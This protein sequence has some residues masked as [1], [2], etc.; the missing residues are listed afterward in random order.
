MNQQHAPWS[1]PSPPNPAGTEPAGA[2]APAAGATPVRG[3]GP[4]S[5]VP[6][7]TTALTGIPDRVPRRVL[8]YHRLAHADPRHEW[9]KPLVEGLILIAGYLLL[10]V[11]FG[12]VFFAV[13]PDRL[14]LDDLL[15]MDQLDPAVFFFMF[16]SVALLLP[17]TL[18]ARLVTGPRPLGLLLSVT[19]RI[20]WGWM[21]RCAL[22]ALGIYVVVNGVSAALSVATGGRPEPPQP[23]PGFWWL[24]LLLVV[25][26]PLQCA[27]EELVF[28]G[29]LAQAV[30]RWLRH[31]AWAVLLP[32]PLF[33]AG[34]IYDVWGLSSVGVMAVTMGV[35]TWRTGGLEAGIAL[36]AVNNCFVTFLGMLGLAD[37]NDTTGAPL[38]LVYELA[39]NALFLV[40]VFR[41]TRRSGIAVTR[42][43]LLPA[44]PRPPATAA[45]PAVLTEDRSGLAVHVVDPRSRRYLT[46]PP[47]YGPYTVRDGRGN[48]VGVLD[49]HSQHGGG[50]GGATAPPGS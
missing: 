17:A 4:G 3:D 40:V 44:P 41:M 45:R 49:V 6:G 47:Q 14:D 22:V 25:V 18:I 38:D 10:S 16:G 9:W 20:R 28:R 43:V 35:V 50:A 39:I 5:A 11:V 33:V 37:M 34:H 15:G 26:V 12:I 29:Y 36:H 42:T 1:R 23:V 8:A 24:L 21:L 32:V 27:S 7:S 19:G 46:L 30:G 2:P 48:P 31:P 13:F